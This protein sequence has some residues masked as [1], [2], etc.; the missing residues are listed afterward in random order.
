[1][2]SLT[3]DLLQ[4][5]SVTDR[6]RTQAIPLSTVKKLPPWIDIIAFSP[7]RWNDPSNRPRELMKRSAQN[8][9]VFFFE[10]PVFDAPDDDYVEIIEREGVNVLIPHLKRKSTSIDSNM[11]KLVGLLLSLAEIHEYVFW[12]FSPLPIRFTRGF[13]PQCRIYDCVN[14]PSWLRM[15]RTREFAQCE[16]KLRVEADVIFTSELKLY[17]A[18]SA[19]RSDVHLFVDA[20]DPKPADWD[21]LWR[22]MNTIV[23]TVIE[24]EIIERAHTN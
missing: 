19:F 11:A 22:Q 14:E 1:M 12:Y 10:E 24:G 4:P 7:V 3:G 20:H 21:L 9:R 6:P 23:Q 16:K 13:A 5:V 18:T 17:L 2:Q 8:R 15:Q